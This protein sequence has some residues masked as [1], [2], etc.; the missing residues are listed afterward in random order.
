MERMVNVS[1][2]NHTPDIVIEINNPVKKP[3]QKSIIA[4]GISITIDGENVSDQFVDVRK[5][6]KYSSR[7]IVPMAHRRAF[8]D[9][10]YANNK[11]SDEYYTELISYERFIKTY[12]LQ[13][14]RVF[15]PFYADGTSTREMASLVDI[16]GRRGANFWDIYKDPEF[17]GLMVLSN[18]PFSFKWQ[19]II[20]L[21][22]ERR[23]F[24]LILPWETFYDK[25]NKDK[26]SV[27]EECPLK[28]YQRKYGGEYVWFK[29]RPHEQL[30]FHPIDNGKL[31]AEGR[32]GVYK[33]IGTHILY[34]R[35]D[36]NFTRDEDYVEKDEQRVASRFKM[37]K[38]FKAWK[39][40][41]NQ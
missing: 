3:V 9:E 31:H 37:R 38:V 34:W 5:K 17:D 15:E 7:E 35:F 27:A 10:L 8:C 16:V 18:P 6:G 41:K 26:T 4:C 14:Q 11:V 19:V 30:F 40:Y 21:L 36:D 29:C 20:T 25:M 12:R 39:T 22:E 32:A 23:N 13:G 1:E 28:K 24:A 33:K 2:T